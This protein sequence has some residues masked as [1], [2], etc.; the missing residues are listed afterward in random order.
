MVGQV[1]FYDVSMG[2][3]VILGADGGL[4]AVRGPQ[5]QGPPLSV[6]ERVVFKPQPAQGGPRATAVRRLRGTHDTG[7][8]G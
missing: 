6:G 1:K 4:Y 5:L 8:G 3:G 2:W 7:T